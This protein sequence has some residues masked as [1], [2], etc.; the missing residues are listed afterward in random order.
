MSK[1]RV[2]R[3][4]VVEDAIKLASVEGLAGVTVGRL[5]ER[6]G[7]SKSGLFAHFRSKEEIDVAI[8]EATIARF[9]EVVIAPALKAPRGEPRLR[10]LIERWI[11]WEN[12]EALLPGG[13]LITQASAELDDRPGKA[14]DVVVRAQRQ[15]YEVLARAVRIAIEEKHLRTD[16]DPQLFA[17]ELQGLFLA[18]HQAQRL[19][20]DPDAFARM[21]R[22]VD[23]LIE[24]SR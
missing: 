21:R 23:T 16:V 3:A 15:W 6:V 11:S 14:R 7:M 18:A 17:F 5:A 1:G 22:A 12:D 20:Q 19:F 9:A 4:R 24:R 8:L 2:T 13:C 10:E